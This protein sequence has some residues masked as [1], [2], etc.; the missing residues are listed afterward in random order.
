MVINTEVLGLIDF[1]DAVIGPISY[2]LVSLLRD[3]YIH[4]PTAQ[5]ETWAYQYYLQ[6]MQAQL[7]A[8]D[9]GQFKRWFDLMGLQ[10]HLKAIGIFSRLHIRDGK[11]R[12]LADIPRTLSYIS[13]VCEN[14][15]ELSAFNRY[16][17]QQIA[18][19]YLSA[20]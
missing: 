16:L 11:S 1:Q 13:E 15:A 12:Y 9:Y 5:V 19:I 17:Q 10:R 7:L 14:Y 6:L 18:P 4:W 2:D 20:L 8:V 3:C